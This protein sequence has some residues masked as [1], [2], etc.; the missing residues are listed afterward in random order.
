MIRQLRIGALFLTVVAA[1]GFGSVTL[2]RRATVDAA[3]TAAQAPRFE[4]DQL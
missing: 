4:V 1:L 3:A 2:D